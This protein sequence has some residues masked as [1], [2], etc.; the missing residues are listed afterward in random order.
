MKRA[1]AQP[2]RGGLAQEAEE[3]ALALF[4]ADLLGDHVFE[5]GEVARK[6]R[7]REHGRRV[8]ALDDGPLHFVDHGLAES[9][10]NLMAARSRERDGATQ[11]HRLDSA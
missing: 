1:N 2:R 5:V 9:V 7:G 8:A 4:E 11:P 10:V 6:V 3:P